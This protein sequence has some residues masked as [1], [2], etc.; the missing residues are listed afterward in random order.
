M[1]NEHSDICKELFKEEINNYLTEILLEKLQGWLKK[2]YKANSKNIKHNKQKIENTQKK[3]LSK[4][5]TY[6]IQ[7]TAKDRK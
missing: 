4:K 3:Q 1:S 5:D 6:E 7:K 2:T